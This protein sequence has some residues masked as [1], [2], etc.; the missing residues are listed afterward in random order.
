MALLPGRTNRRFP[1]YK[2]EASVNIGIL[3]GTSPTSVK[4]VCTVLGE[5]GAGVR[6]SE[7]LSVDEIVYLQIPLPHRPL[8]LPATVRYQHGADY[9]VEFLALGATERE[10]IRTTCSAF[11]RVG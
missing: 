11:P 5:G 7:P 3:R 10:F 8:Q 4:G 1:R 6:T 9:G 2:Y